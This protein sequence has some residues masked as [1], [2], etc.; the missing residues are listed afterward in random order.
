MN[1]RS[2]SLNRRCV[3]GA[4]GAYRNV[5]L[6]ATRIEPDCILQDD[7]GISVDRGLISAT[8]AANLG[9]V[10]GCELQRIGR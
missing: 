1:S 9:Q 3:K 7:V 6:Y 8:F 4:N 2:E 10:S 5:E